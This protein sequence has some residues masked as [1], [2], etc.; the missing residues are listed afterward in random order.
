MIDL[1]FI[2]INSLIF[3]FM[4]LTLNKVNCN[5]PMQFLNSL[6]YDNYI[7]RSQKNSLTLRPSV[8]P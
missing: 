5:K 4:Y 3:F 7:G 2:I 6:N 8:I 1:C